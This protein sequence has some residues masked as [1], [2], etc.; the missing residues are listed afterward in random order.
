MPVTN[1]VPNPSVAPDLDDGM[2]VMP[3]R[4]G[5]RDDGEDPRSRTPK[6]VF[7]KLLT[8]EGVTMTIEARMATRRGVR[9]MLPR[10]QRLVRDR[11]RRHGAARV[12]C[13]SYCE[14]CV[15]FLM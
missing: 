9:M 5:E 1:T 12:K 3:P 7:P 13:A 8:D 14:N 10:P 6:S 11:R 2:A 4:I 15:G